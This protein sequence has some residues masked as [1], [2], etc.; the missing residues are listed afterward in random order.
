MITMR[1]NDLICLGNEFLLEQLEGRSLTSRQQKEL[2]AHLKTC[3]RCKRHASW[4]HGTNHLLQLAIEDRDPPTFDVLA[5]VWRSIASRTELSL[6]RFLDKAG[7]RLLISGGA[8]RNRVVSVQPPPFGRS[9]AGVAECLRTLKQLDRSQNLRAVSELVRRMWRQRPDSPSSLAMASALFTQAVE[10]DECFPT[11]VLHRLQATKP[12]STLSQ[13]EK[14][15]DHL[16][17]SSP[18]P[19]PRA[20]AL[21]ELAATYLRLGRDAERAADL[22]SWACQIEPR[23]IVV[24]SS[25]IYALAAGRIAPHQFEKQLRSTYKRLTKTQADRDRSQFRRVMSQ[26]TFWLQKLGWLSH[27]RR[28]KTE[29]IMTKV[30][31]P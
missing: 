16:L 12:G 7:Q 23:P 18:E 11:A 30:W 5:K 6:A 14:E 19:A 1:E 2:S 9:I 25:L 24:G 13:V 29:A 3:S 17:Q 21:I 22:A 4:I 15:V 26:A 31:E 8:A 28:V 20:V 10:L 27:D